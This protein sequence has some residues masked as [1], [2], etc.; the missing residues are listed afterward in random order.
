MDHA[1]RQDGNRYLRRLNRS[2][3]DAPRLSESTITR[4]QQ[5]VRVYLDGGADP[6]IDAQCESTENRQRI[7]IGSD[8]NGASTFDGK[9]DEV[10]LFDRA[11]A[12]SDIVELYEKSGH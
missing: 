3:H 5:H 7:L 6:E 1:Q 12:A 10:A 11:I 8:G 2:S 9:I 4:A